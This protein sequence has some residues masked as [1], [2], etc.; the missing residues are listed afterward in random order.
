MY[1]FGHNFGMYIKRYEAVNVQLNAKTQES[2]Y[3][4]LRIFNR[5]PFRVD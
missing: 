4:Y 3:Y 2:L 5:F 1:Q